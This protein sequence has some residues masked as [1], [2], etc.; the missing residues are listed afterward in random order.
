MIGVLFV[1]GP[2]HGGRHPID[3]LASELPLSINV[4][5]PMKI[6]AFDITTVVAPVPYA[7]YDLRWGSLAGSRGLERTPIYL[8]SGAERYG[9]GPIDGGTTSTDRSLADH[10]LAEAYPRRIPRCVVPEC[11]KYAPMLFLADEYGRLAGRWWEPGDEIRLCPGHGA[12][13]YRAQYTRGID[14]LPEWLRPDANLGALDACD[15]GHDRLFHD[16][17][18]RQGARG[19]LVRK[20]KP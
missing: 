11:P 16:Q 19:L 13:V 15:A 1:G 17:I 8:N 5:I 4:P 10:L 14:M 7:V 18:I 20:A 9:Q 2:R 6:T 12:D 3:A